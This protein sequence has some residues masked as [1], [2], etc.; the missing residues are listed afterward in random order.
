MAAGQA[1]SS[2]CT[3]PTRSDCVTFTFH[4]VAADQTIPRHSPSRSFALNLAHEWMAGNAARDSLQERQLCRRHRSISP[5]LTAYFSLPKIGPVL[6]RVCSSSRLPFYSS[7]FGPGEFTS[8]PCGKSEKQMR[9]KTAIAEV[10]LAT[11]LEPFP[12]S[13]RG[14]RTF[15]AGS[16]ASPPKREFQ[17]PSQLQTFSLWRVR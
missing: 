13:R 5:H 6:W 16:A 12:A 10:Q 9:R 11:T 15:P 17:V 7:A 8:A 4:N 3:R 14:P 1:G 2:C